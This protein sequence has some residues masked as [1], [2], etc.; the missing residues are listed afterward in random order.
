MN[1]P[2]AYTKSTVTM[3]G[4]RQLLVRTSIDQLHCRGLKIIVRQIE[5]MAIADSEIQPEDFYPP[6]RQYMG[7]SRDLLML[8]SEQRTALL[9]DLNLRIDKSVTGPPPLF[10]IPLKGVPCSPNTLQE[11]MAMMLRD[12]AVGENHSSHRGRCSFITS[13]VNKQIKC[14]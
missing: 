4:I 14:P 10:F 12:R 5:S 13:V 2:A 6:V 11:H 7:K 3:H 9:D 1:L 8:D